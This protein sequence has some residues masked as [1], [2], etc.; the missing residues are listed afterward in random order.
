MEQK[1][2]RLL[3]FAAVNKMTLLDYPDHLAAVL[4]T[5]GC[6][7]RCF[8]CHNP[9]FMLYND[10]LEA[11]IPFE[12][13][14]KFIDS[15]SGFLDGIVISGG[16]PTLH[17]S[18]IPTISKIK[19][20]GMKVKLDTNGSRPDVILELIERKLIDYLAMDFKCLPE[21]YSKFCDFLMPPNKLKAS[22]KAVKSLGIP[23][24]FRTTIWQEYHTI[25][26]LEEMGKQINGAQRW[27]LQNI[28]KDAVFGDCSMSTPFN[29]A[30]LEKYKDIL[31]PY[32]DT[33]DVR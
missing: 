21:D 6:N 5:Q 33:I 18:L 13:I 20:M 25:S 9:L 24:E 3:S 28:R 15:R 8:Y 19:E 27:A 2:N 32:A 17:K 30:R 26:C 11:D 14:E 16:E 10:T 23:Y 7:F 29:P 31:S 22:I 4:F 12:A 1:K